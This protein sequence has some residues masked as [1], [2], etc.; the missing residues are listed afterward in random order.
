MRQKINR[1]K[2]GAL[3]YF[4]IFVHII[5]QKTF[6]MAN[7]GIHISAKVAR[8]KF[9]CNRGFGLCDIVIDID[10][11]FMRGILTIDSE[12]GTASLEFLEKP[13]TDGSDTF[14]IEKNIKLP[15]K[16]AEYL[17]YKNIQILRGEYPFNTFTSKFG[18]VERI[19]VN[20]KDDEDCCC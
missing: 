3:K 1:L 11:N 7:I 2:F 15:L 14:Y 6:T 10:I 9:D 18:V 20:L 16:A 12:E 5:N 8:A 19:Q 4:Y 17:G 13:I